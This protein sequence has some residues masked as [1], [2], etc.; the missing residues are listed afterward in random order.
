MDGSFLGGQLVQQYLKKVLQFNRHLVTAIGDHPSPNHIG[1]CAL[2]QQCKI[3]LFETRRI[4]AIGDKERIL[5][6]KS[7]SK[8]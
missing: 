3:S 7:I 4:R 6:K 8:K 2:N 1:R 5:K